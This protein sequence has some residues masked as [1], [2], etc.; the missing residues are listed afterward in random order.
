MYVLGPTCPGENRDG[1]GPVLSSRPLPVCCAA[2]V[3]VYGA[4]DN[5]VG[6]SEDEEFSK[7]F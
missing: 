3:S 6:N 5:A 7:T 4:K 2:D 1:E